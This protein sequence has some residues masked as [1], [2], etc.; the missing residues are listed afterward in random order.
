MKQKINLRLIFIAVIAVVFT[1]VSTVLVSY[2]LFQKQVKKDL[3]KEALLIQSVG[4]EHLTLNEE[5]RDNKE[6]RVTWIDQ[7]GTVLFDNDANAQVLENHRNRPEVVEA[8]EKGE[9]SSVRKSDTMNMKNYYYA[10][11]LPDH[12]ILRIATEA[13]SVISIFMSA[14]PILLGLLLLIIVMCIML[15]HML[16]RQL[17]LPIAKMA[18]NLENS[19]YHS[20]YKELTPFIQT[21][22][23][24]H[25][26][27]LSAARSRQDFSANVSHELKTPLTAISGYAELIE[28]EMVDEESQKRFAGE[29]RKNSNRLLSLIND[30]IRL[31][32][33]DQSEQHVLQENLD[34]YQL[35]EES[36]NDLLEFARQKHVNICFMGQPAMLL[37]NRTMMKELLDN[38]C[39]NAIRYNVEN[40]SVQVK[41]GKEAEHVFLRVSDTGIG[42]PKEEQE[43][44]FERFYRVD[45]SRSRETGGT[46]LGLAIVKHIVEL[47][48]AKLELESEPM[49]GTT[50]TILF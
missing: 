35:M 43:R 20:E 14:L 45:K 4:I 24:Q 12:T 15:S 9:G 17:L 39:Q 34:L 3:K 29:I 32:E 44:I 46:G 49:K 2:N 41:V 47:H 33:L 37:A 11:Q 30:I 38:L 1:A 8:I 22:R 13:Q 27:I 5:F 7:D 42:I 16:T 10:L 48:G 25:E 23:S 26:D 36:K 50:I 21:I 31:S 6:I 18:D 40:G 28:N 19:S